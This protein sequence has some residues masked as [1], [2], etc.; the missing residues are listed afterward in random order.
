[1]KNLGSKFMIDL[2]NVT[3]MTI[4]GVGNDQNAVKA[5]KYSST[6]I[7]FASIK[8]ITAGSLV[9]NFCETVKISKMSWNQYNKFCLTDLYKYVD[10]DYVILIQS[11]GF[12]IN[13]KCWNDHFLQYDYIG[14][15]WPSRNITS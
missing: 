1:M 14:A 5:L 12:I 4:D 9:P 2:D 11:D 13:S 3:L 15:P 6:D 7:N 8:Y 10:S